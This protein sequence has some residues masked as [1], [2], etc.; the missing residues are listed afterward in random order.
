MAFRSLFMAHAPDAEC[1]RHRSIIDTGKLRLF[2]VIV[3]DQKEAVETA[4][5]LYESEGIDAVLLCPGFSHRDAAEI[6]DSLKGKVS[7]SVAR[8]DGPSNRIVLPVIQRE[9]SD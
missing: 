9:Y 8:G 1:S 7:V 4:K 2:S 3:R 5:E 6:F